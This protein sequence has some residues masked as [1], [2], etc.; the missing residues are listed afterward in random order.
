MPLRFIAFEVLHRH[1]FLHRFD[2]PLDKF[3][4]MLSHL[5]QVINQM[6]IPIT[7]TC[8]LVMYFLQ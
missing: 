2:I 3:E 7:I 5:E 1:G 8:M 6:K 4:T